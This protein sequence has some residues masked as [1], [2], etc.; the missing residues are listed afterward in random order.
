MTM[1]QILAG[2]LLLAMPGI[3]D[4]RFDHTL[5]YLHEHSSEGAMGF[6]IN[7]RAEEITLADIVESMSLP[8]L[9]RSPTD[10]VYI[11]G[12]VDTGRGFV[13]HDNSYKSNNTVFNK[14]GEIGV[15]TT[16]DILEVICSRNPLENAMTILGYSGWVSG[17]LERELQENVWL[18]C[19]FNLELVFTITAEKK[20]QAAMALMGIDPGQLSSYQGS[21]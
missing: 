13:L 15:T 5:I 20:Y 10:P 6:V 18:V 7:Q 11:G 3:D 21:A 1:T 2:Q 8:D 19:P 12:P 16:Q 9:E 4:T 17:Q 14:T